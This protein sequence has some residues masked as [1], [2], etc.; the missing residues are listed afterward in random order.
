MTT[1]PL[2]QFSEALADRLAAASRF[3]VSIRTGR[4][5]CSGILWRDDVVVTSEQLMPEGPNFTAVH[6]GAEIQANLAGCDAGHQRRRAAPGARSWTRALPATAASPRPGSLALVVGADARGAPTGRLGMVHA[7]GPEWHSQSGGRIEALLRLDARLG[8]DE[9]GPV[10]TLG[11]RLIGMSTSGPRRRALVIPAATIE[12]V[13]DPLLTDGRI[14]RGW[15]GVGLQQVLV[16]ERLREAAGRDAG[17]MVVGLAPGAPAEQAGVLPGDII[18]EVDGRRTGRS[19]RPGDGAG[20]GTHRPA[21]HAEAAARRRG[22]SGDRDDRRPP[23]QDMSDGL[24]VLLRA[25]DPVRRQGLAAM[26]EAAGHTPV[27]E[28]PDVVLCDLARDA[29]PPG[30][31]E[32]PVRRADRPVAARRAARRRAAAHGHRRAARSRRCGRSR[33]GCWCGRRAAFQPTGSTPPART[34]RRC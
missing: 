10:L 27:S 34:R 9:G 17:M 19:A 8:A 6:N 33:P 15:L 20:G 12:R 1:D 5:D 23:H 14:A 4:R 11:G 29:V 30:E 32:A 25:G 31:A 16:P 13:L 26:L 24:R 22:A 3:V 2:E 28:T 21:R 7:T 18:L